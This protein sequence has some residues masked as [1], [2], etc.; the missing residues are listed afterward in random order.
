MQSL[1]ISLPDTSQLC[2]C[3]N[4]ILKNFDTSMRYFSFNHVFTTFFHLKM[5]HGKE[6][7]GGYHAYNKIPRVA[8]LLTCW[9][10]TS[11]VHVLRQR[12]KW[13]PYHPFDL[14]SEIK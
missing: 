3:I 10:R 14:H 8:R 4:Y 13:N 9:V 11:E 5:M 1:S 7:K 6:S 12:T 2:I